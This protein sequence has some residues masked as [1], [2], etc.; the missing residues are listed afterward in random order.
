MNYDWDFSVFLPYIPALARGA[1]VTIELSV[2]SSII[3][4][5]LGVALGIVYRLKPID[6]VLLPINDILRAVPLLVL[7]FFVYYFPY[8][9]LL[10]VPAPSAFVCATVALTIA[11]AVYTADIVRAA[12]DGVSQGSILGARSVGL[13]ENEIWRYIILP[14]IF[15]Q[16]APSLVAFYIGNI[17]MSSLASVIGCEDVVFVARTAISQ[18]FRSLEAWTIV[19]VIYVILVLPLTIAA[20]KLESSEWLKRR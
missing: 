19:A 9:E 10:G 6:R 11:Q 2:I 3:G 15:R 4:T 14:D 18:R 16:I 20:R 17:R 7:I 5:L 12:V 8:T 13:R 1:L